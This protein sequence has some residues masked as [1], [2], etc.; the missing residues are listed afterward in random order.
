MY[1][2]PV[3][4]WY[5]M[6][7]CFVS[8]VFRASTSYFVSAF[9]N[10]QLHLSQ[11]VS[12]GTGALGR[13]SLVVIRFCTWLGRLRTPGDQPGVLVWKQRSVLSRSVLCVYARVHIYKHCTVNYMTFK[14]GVC[15]LSLFSCI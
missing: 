9:H 15:L 7:L 2:Q 10:F 1:R 14:G 5:Q 13:W 11:R 8:L 12:F 6:P 4:L 3:N